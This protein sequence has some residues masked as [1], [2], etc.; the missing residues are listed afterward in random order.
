[1]VSL[2]KKSKPNR[3][4]KMLAANFEEMAEDDRENRDNYDKTP[5]PT[6]RR[7]IEY[8]DHRLKLYSDAIDTYIQP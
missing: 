5:S 2:Q 8:T 7:W 3:I 6:G 1:M 4:R